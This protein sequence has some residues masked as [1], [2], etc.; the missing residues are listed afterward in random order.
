[1]TDTEFPVYYKKYLLENC[2]HYDHQD[3]KILTVIGSGGS[4]SVYSAY[5][6]NT[7]SKFAIKKIA[8]LSAEKDIINEI[9]LMKIVDFHPNIIK[10]LGVI[11][12]E[13]NYSLVLEYADGGTL[14]EYLDN[15]IKLDPE[16]QLKFAKEIA[17]AILCLHDNDIIHRDIHP[18]NILIHGH[19]IKLADFG[20]SCLQGSNVDTKAFGV[21][22]YMD[23][24]MLD[25]QIPYNLTKKSDIYSLGVI[26]WQLTSCS[27]PF[28]FE[29][30]KDP[31][32][33]TLDILNGARED[34]IPN[35]NTKFVRLYQQ[36]WRNEPDKR[37]DANQVISELNDIGCKN[38]SNFEESENE[39]I[40]ITDDDENNDDFSDCNL[41]NY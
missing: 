12:G 14:G 10:F 21:I 15:T 34:P 1:M 5:W 32:S 6:K 13:I 19:T 35:S 25:Q 27:S 8:K 23:P 36:C 22:P 20:Q 16:I 28:N 9:S 2:R 41:S 37:P 11:K 31:A 39:K 17:S 30:R 29:K 3:F 4:A 40:K 7:T 24:K 33:I 18:N 26:F 38:S